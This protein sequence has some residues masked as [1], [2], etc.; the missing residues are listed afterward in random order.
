MKT[1]DLYLRAQE[2]TTDQKVGSSNLSEHA[3]Y[4]ISEAILLNDPQS[5]FM[6]MSRIKAWR[7]PREHKRIHFK[8][9]GKIKK[10]VKRRLVDT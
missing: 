5:E 8:L 4:P 9:K 1:H 6:K 3:H 7:S 2:P 10:P